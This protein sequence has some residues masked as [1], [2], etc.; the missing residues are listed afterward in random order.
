MR[1][2]IMKKKNMVILTA[3]VVVLVVAV[4]SAN[5]FFLPR[6]S[7]T[8]LQKID[9][10]MTVKII[11]AR[12]MLG[13]NADTDALKF[14]VVSPGI[15]AMRKVKVQHPDDALVRVA[16]EGELA[17]WTS[18]SP[19]EFNLSAGETTEVALEVSVPNYALPGN[20][21]GTAVFCI[22]EQ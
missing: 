2:I 21:S 19:A 16:M 11:S 10:T 4:L 9:A 12:A 7:C 22:K 13:L 3:T 18:I 5:L 17:R 15:T 20:Y 1:E 8:A 6:S 14:G